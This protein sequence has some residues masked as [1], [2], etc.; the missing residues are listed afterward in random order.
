MFRR[1]KKDFLV[2][3]GLNPDFV[4]IGG[5]IGMTSQVQAF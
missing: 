2:E 3:A 5:L 1:N 4:G